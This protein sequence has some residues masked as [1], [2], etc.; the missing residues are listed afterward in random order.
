[1]ANSMRADSTSPGVAHAI[2][3]RVMHVPKL[4]DWLY[5]EKVGYGLRVQSLVAHG[6]GSVDP[7]LL[8]QLQRYYAPDAPARLP[9]AETRY[10]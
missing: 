9:V 3:N 7:D 5:G 6:D 4:H 1:M 2:H 10:A 8:A